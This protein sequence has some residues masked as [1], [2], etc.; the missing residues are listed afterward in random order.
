MESALEGHVYER[1]ADGL[2]RYV[3]SGGGGAPL[4]DVGAPLPQTRHA[5]AAY[6][7]VKVTVASDKVTVA[8]KRADDTPI[9]TAS[10]TK[11]DHAWDGEPDPVKKAAPAS[12][13][14]KQEDKC[15]CAVVGAESAIPKS[16]L[17]AL[18]AILGAFGLRRRRVDP[19]SGEALR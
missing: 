18:T 9:E 10:F 12:F 3:V 2:L 13:S 17:L 7:Y 8:A 11:S 1:G 16:S 14:A 19:R 5:E 4:Y 6:H 15:N